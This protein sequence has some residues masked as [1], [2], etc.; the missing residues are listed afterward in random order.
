[1]GFLDKL[2][3]NSPNKDI[4]PAPVAPPKKVIIVEDDKELR[5][6]YSELLSSEGFTTLTAENGQIGL[7]TIMAQKPDLVLLDLMMPV[8]DGKMMLHKMRNIPEFAKTPVIV[9]T[10][11]GDADNMRQ[12]QYFDNASA[13]LI[14]ANVTPDEIINRVKTFT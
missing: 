8:M 6:F 9:L 3:G 4:Q 7:Q 14:K 13:F 2:V 10:N 11:A 1:M 12:T 5:D